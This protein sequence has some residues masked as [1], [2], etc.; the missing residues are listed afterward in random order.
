MNAVIRLAAAFLSMAA[1]VGASSSAAQA[2]QVV[3]SPDFNVRLLIPK[4]W[5]WEPKSNGPFISCA[6]K[7]ANPVDCYLSVERRKAAPG[8]GGITD[9]NRQQWKD[10]ASGGGMQQ[11]QSARDVRIAGYPAFETV[12]KAGRDTIYRVFILM[13]SP[14]RV[15]DVTFYGSGDGKNDYYRQN[16]PAVDTVLGSLAPASRTPGR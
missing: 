3:E 4:S 2:T 6:P 5:S 16:K 12:S 9:A 7:A 14:P 15:I 11:V 8:Q 1:I 13:D 10:W